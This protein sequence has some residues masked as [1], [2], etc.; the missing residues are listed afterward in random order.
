MQHTS[1]ALPVALALI[2]LVVAAVVRA[3]GSV[4]KPRYKPSRILTDNETEF[5]WRLRQ[6]LPDEL[7]FPQVA[8]SALIQP[9]TS[10]KQRFSDFGRIAQKRVD[11]AIYDQMFGLIAV[12]ELDDRTHDA[13]KDAIRDAYLASAGIRTVR[14][15]SKAKPD[16]SEIRTKV[17][18]PVY[19][20]PEAHLKAV[21]A[22]AT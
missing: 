5:Y 1:I 18:P 7:I 9:V 3:K 6:A 22:D 13:K 21:D 11:F 8:M 16:A 17:F 19:R 20:K 4:A 15:Q 2:V 10:G 12:V 14:F